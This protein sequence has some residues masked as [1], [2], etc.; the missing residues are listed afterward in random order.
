[1]NACARNAATVIRIA[2]GTKKRPI[3]NPAIRQQSPSSTAETTAARRVVRR[4]GRSE[5]AT[6]IDAMNRIH[7]PLTANPVADPHVPPA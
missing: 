3:E 7:H 1:V 4:T 5:I 6:G 2:A